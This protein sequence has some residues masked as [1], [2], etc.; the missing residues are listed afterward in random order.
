[1]FMAGSITNSLPV[2]NSRTITISPFAGASNISPSIDY[3]R[4]T[5]MVPSGSEAEINQM[6]ASGYADAEKWIRAMCASGTLHPRVLKTT[7]E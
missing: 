2:V 3:S 1:M 7:S 4:L 5:Q 6:Y